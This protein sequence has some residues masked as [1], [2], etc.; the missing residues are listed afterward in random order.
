MEKQLAKVSDEALSDLS[1]IFDEVVVS[2]ILLKIEQNQKVLTKEINEIS[3]D[4]KA[5]D[6]QLKDIKEIKNKVGSFNEDYFDEND[7]NRA[8]FD[9]RDNIVISSVLTGLVKKSQET[10]TKLVRLTNLM[11]DP[12]AVEEEKTDDGSRNSLVTLIKTNADK[13]IEEVV[14]VKNYLNDEIMVKSQL[15]QKFS[16][17]IES[18]KEIKKQLAVLMESLERINLDSEKRTVDLKGAIQS[19]F[20]MQNTSMD[21]GLKQQRE[22]SNKVSHEIE[23]LKLKMNARYDESINLSNEKSQITNKFLKVLTGLGT[24]AIL[25]I[26]TLIIMIMM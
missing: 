3:E 16:E 1:S 13:N 10:N 20:A 22:E 14:K 8:C 2:K 12:A 15:H 24:V 25:G 9:D 26:V 6:E 11:G 21:L 18:Q 19:S 17:I 23:D 7:E 5:Q 4:L